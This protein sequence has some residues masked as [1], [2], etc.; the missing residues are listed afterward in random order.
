MIQRIQ[1]V[2]LLL[3]LILA[4]SLLFLPF[5]NANINNETVKLCLNPVCFSDSVKSFIWLPFI[6]LCALVILTIVC[7]LSYKNRAKQTRFCRILMIDHALL[8]IVLMTLN[9]IKEPATSQTTWF[10][11]IPAFNIILILLAMRSIKK[12]EEL[13]RSADRLR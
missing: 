6:L 10:A 12:D 3:V 2:Y 4:S 8:S 9:Y 11:L 5:A 13:V 7:I 1:S